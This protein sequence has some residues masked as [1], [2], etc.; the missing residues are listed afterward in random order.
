VSALRFASLPI[1]ICACVVSLHYSTDS[2]SRGRR[3]GEGGGREAIE[4][5]YTRDL[6]IWYGCGV[7]DEAGMRNSSTVISSVYVSCVIDIIVKY[8]THTHLK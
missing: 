1:H 4:R 8:H 7:G 5:A 2:H 6:N 3:E